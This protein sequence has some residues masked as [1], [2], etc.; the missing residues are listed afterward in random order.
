M[1]GIESLRK[2]P[3]RLGELKPLKQVKPSYQTAEAPGLYGLTL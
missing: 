1:I 2:L 3:C